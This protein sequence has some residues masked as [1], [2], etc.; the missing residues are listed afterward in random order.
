MESRDLV[1]GDIVKLAMGD[2][3]PADPREGR[4]VLERHPG[5]DGE[6]TTPFLGPVWAPGLSQK[7]SKTVEY[8]LWRHFAPL[9]AAT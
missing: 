8:A 5:T 6:P 2:V 7:T 9:Y 4:G 3:V 1:R